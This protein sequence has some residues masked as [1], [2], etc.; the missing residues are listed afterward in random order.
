MIFQ[1]SLHKC[2][3]FVLSFVIMTCSLFAQENN[4]SPRIEILHM[5][6]TQSE[7]HALSVFK[8]AVQKQGVDWKDY[9]TKGNFDGIHKQLTGKLSMNSSPSAVQWIVS[10]N[11]STL[12]KSGLFRLIEDPDN[13]YKEQ[14]RPEIYD[15][16]RMEGGLSAIPVGIHT[17]N[18]I[19]YNKTLLKQLGLDEAPKTWS[20]LINLGPKLKEMNKSL[21]AVSNEDWQMRVMFISLLAA[22]FTADEYNRFQTEGSN[23][24]DLTDKLANAFHILK[25]L[26]KYASDDYNNVAW[27]KVAQKVAKGDALIQILGDYIIPE[28]PDRNNIV[29]SPSLE[30]N[31][32][33]WGVDAF[34]LPKIDEEA[35]IAGQDAFLRTVTDREAVIEYVTRKG[36]LPIVSNVSSDLLDN[37]LSK[38]LDG[39]NDANQRVHMGG[40]TWQ[41]RLG[42]IGN[43]L[44]NNWYKGF[45]EPQKLAD[46]LIKILKNI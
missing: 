15:L 33:V 8:E 43:F 10:R 42:V 40:E 5:W 26:H 39:W 45:D 30:S 22:V 34:V 17:Q 19:V 27:E 35:V 28:Y 23:I 4:I 24:D 18:V 6:R 41:K 20:E 38:I 16:V 44:R 25:G 12:V 21:I 29:C 13:K 9:A 46:L 1:N 7:Q 31:Y 37:C 11:M 36:G 32:T 14:L 2:F 3:L